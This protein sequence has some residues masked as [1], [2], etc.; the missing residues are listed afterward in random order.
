MK[1][2]QEKEMKK[3]RN[4]IIPIC[5]I[6]ILLTLFIFTSLVNA[7]A[8]QL[9]NNNNK[10]VLKVKIPDGI[11]LYYSSVKNLKNNE[12]SPLIIVKNGQLLN[13][14]KIAEKV[15]TSKMMEDYS[16]GKTFNVFKA[17]EKAGEISDIKFKTEYCF[18]KPRNSK[19]KILP[20]ITG[21]GKYTGQSLPVVESSKEAWPMGVPEIIVT[22]L[23]FS[24][25]KNIKRPP[26]KKEDHKK[27][28]S[29]FRK[30]LLPKVWEEHNKKL[31]KIGRHI[32]SE[33]N[34]YLFVAEAV[35][36]YGN[37]NKDVI[38]IYYEVFRIAEGKDDAGLSNID[39]PFVLWS[40][41]KI[42]KLDLRDLVPSYSFIGVIDIDGDGMKELIVE[43]IIEV[44]SRDDDASFATIAIEILKN[45]NDR[46]VSIWNSGLICTS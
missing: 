19:Q 1:I 36:I 14:Y 15:G 31:K 16:I 45:K 9:I 28:I 39:I 20:E 10:Q 12:V 22:P 7:N 32:V 40:N 42:D 38:G 25:G 35:D 2:F 23:T 8:T 24:Y 29:A 34:S 4:R 11:Y 46:W 18:A 30:N 5:L 27:I 3:M 21:V 44:E 33:K 6:P 37:G 13:P 26:L 17:L 41:G 43:K